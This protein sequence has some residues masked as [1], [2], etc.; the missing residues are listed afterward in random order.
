MAHDCREKDKM[1]VSLAEKK[2]IVE[3]VS[4]VASSAHA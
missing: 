1:A 4:E 2:A 3:A